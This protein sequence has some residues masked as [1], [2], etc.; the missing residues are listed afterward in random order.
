MTRYSILFIM[1]LLALTFQAKAT[2]DTE[3]FVESTERSQ[4]TPNIDKGNWVIAPIPVSN[5]TLGTGLQ[6]AALYLHP[7]RGK[8]DSSPNATSG[9]GVMYTDN[10]SWFAGLFHKT[11]LY[12]D[13]LRLM[14]A[15]GKGSLQL[16][17]FGSGGGGVLAENPVGYSL[18]TNIG[19]ARAQW[20][21]PGTEHWFFGPAYTY[22]QGDVTLD[23]SSL[24][25]SLPA[26]GKG[27]LVSGLG[28]TLTYDSRDSNYY[29]TEGVDFGISSYYYGDNLGSDFNFSK[30]TVYLSNYFP[31]SPKMVIASNAY[32]ESGA[33]DVPFFMLSSPGV[34]GYDRGRYMDDGALKLSL[35]SRYKFAARWSAV[36]FYDYGWVSDKADQLLSGKT[37]YSIGGGIRWQT[38]PDKPLNLGIDVAY[39]GDNDTVVFIQIGEQF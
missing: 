13:R 26:V 4:L 35:E 29:P 11:Y 16:K 38:T 6:L 28:L 37:A 32:Y 25:P 33:G 24:V 12:D 36:G 17:Y 20:R 19:F 14:V 9:L 30:T 27:V 1:G 15:A 21:L 10:D 18:D 39:T 23:F 31:V 2:D 22:G 8:S 5:P 34:R 3:A 7:S